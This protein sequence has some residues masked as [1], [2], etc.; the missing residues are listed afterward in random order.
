MQGKLKD[1]CQTAAKEL[2]VSWSFNCNA[3]PKNHKALL[4]GDPK[5]EIKSQTNE[6]IPLAPGSVNRG[7]PLFRRPTFCR[8]SFLDLLER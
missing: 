6:L 3:K 1:P 5:V 8:P 4:T 2:S 7:K